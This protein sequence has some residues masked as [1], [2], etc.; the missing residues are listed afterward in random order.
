MALRILCHQSPHS[1]LSQDL[2]LQSPDLW[3]CGNQLAAPLLAFN[4]HY[5]TKVKCQSNRAWRGVSPVMNGCWGGERKPLCR[6]VQGGQLICPALGWEQ[7]GLHNSRTAMGPRLCPA[8]AG[9]KDW[10]AQDT[11]YWCSWTEQ[12]SSSCCIFSDAQSSNLPSGLGKQKHN[13]YLGKHLGCIFTTH[14]KQRVRERFFPR[15]AFFSASLKWAKGKSFSREVLTQLV[16]V[17]WPGSK[18]LI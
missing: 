16:Q 9:T 11:V 4:S 8:R 6:V 2:T 18:V 1:L 17:T 12:L 13:A 7:L 3:P 15:F 5:S 10:S 14:Q